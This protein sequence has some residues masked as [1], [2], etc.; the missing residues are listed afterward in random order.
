MIMRTENCVVC[1]AVLQNGVSEWHKVCS[2]CGYEAGILEPII[3]NSNAHQRIDESKRE[4]GLGTLRQENFLKILKVLTELGH[5][6]GERLLDVG[7]AHGWFL[8]LA[9]ER[10]KVLGI[11]P[12]S[13]VLLGIEKKGLPV[14]H[15]FFPQSLDAGEKFDIIIF[16][17]VIEHIPDIVN[18][19]RSC[20]EHLSEGGCLVLNLPSSNGMFYRASKVLIAIGIKRYFR[21]MWQF[22]FPS[23]H[24]HY[25]NE[26]NLPCLVEKFGFEKVYSGRL[27]SVS[28]RGLLDRIRHVDKGSKLGALLLYVG[29]LAMLPILH[30]MPS[31][32]ML[33]VFRKC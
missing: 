20:A 9:Q 4:Y 2:E 31:D 16:N 13:V 30:L 32:V 33:Q 27:P 22:G 10:F 3:N 23:P 29:I 6:R 24:L 12:D 17:D 11:E 26:N 21:R 8:E 1:G 15:G 5:K 19:V 25:L 7:A 28:K 18:A 14:R